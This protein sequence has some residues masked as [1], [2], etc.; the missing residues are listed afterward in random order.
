MGR[1]NSNLSWILW[2]KANTPTFI[3]G[4]PL[5][6]AWGR[7]QEPQLINGWVPAWEVECQW[8]NVNIHTSVD[9][10]SAQVCDPLVTSSRS[11]GP[12]FS[13][14][15]DICDEG[16]LSNGSRHPSGRKWDCD[17]WL[18]SPL[19]NLTLIHSAH[20]LHRMSAAA[21]QKLWERERSLSDPGQVP[22]PASIHAWLYP[23]SLCDLG[24]VVL[25][26]RPPS[27]NL[28]VVELM[29]SS[30]VWVVEGCIEDSK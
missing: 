27:P 17:A 2:W 22:G 25:L 9:W 14:A 12:G 1:W 15:S 5:S 20:S 3:Y 26:T 8:V 18:F 11:K 28:V 29:W 6:K 7:L 23:L 24:K 13:E 4:S 10:I 21:S 19:P 30:P 16:W